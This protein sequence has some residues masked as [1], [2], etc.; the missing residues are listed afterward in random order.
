MLGLLAITSMEIVLKT[1]CMLSICVCI[2]KWYGVLE[3]ILCVLHLDAER[4]I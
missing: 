1:A 3:I 4:I 2:E